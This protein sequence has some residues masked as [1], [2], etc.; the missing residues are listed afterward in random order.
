MRWWLAIA[1]FLGLFMTSPSARADGPTFDELKK[2]G[3]EAMSNLDYAS[4]IE[5]FRA[6][7]VIKNDDGV[8]L[9]NLGRALQA[10]EDFPAALDALDA[11]DQRATPEV[12]AKVPKLA[13]LRAAVLARVG[14]L[15]F[16]CSQVVTG[17]TLSI[18]ERKLTLDCAPAP[19]TLRLSVAAVPAPL[20]VRYETATLTSPEVKISLPGGGPPTKLVLEVSPRA[21]SGFLSIRAEPVSAK[22]LVDGVDRGNPPVDLALPKGAHKVVLEAS[23]YERHESEVLIEIGQ[24]RELSL[25]LQRTPAIT[26][27]WWFWTGA[28]VIVAGAVV[29]VWYL[30]AQPEKDA[31]AGSIAPGQ[32][33]APSF[34]F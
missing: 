34:R 6:A 24:R 18:G 10:R 3:N 15:T 8:V 13:E 33:H 27:R 11:F 30:V 32:L 7:L 17:G 12:R 5:A 2:R 4:A 14:T 20:A 26:S 25:Q 22:I 28:A 29:G 9:Y 1:L 19:Q 16:S 21:T 23:R 31:S